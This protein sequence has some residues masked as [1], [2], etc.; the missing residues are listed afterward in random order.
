MLYL[1]YKKI[2]S[3]QI[4][5]T[6]E[7]SNILNSFTKESNGMIIESIRLSN[8]YKALKNKFN[9][10]FKKEQEI[11]KL[12]MKLFKKEMRDESLAKRFKI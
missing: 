3:K 8:E 6:D 12:G 2:R 1:E 7:L 10:E 5:I 9:I 11:T 4:T